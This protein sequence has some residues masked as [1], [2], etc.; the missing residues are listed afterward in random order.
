M[1]LA[2]AVGASLPGPAMAQAYGQLLDSEIPFVTATGR[3]LG[4][5][6]RPKPELEQIG[7]PLGGFR[8]FPSLQAGV[9]FT[10]NVIGADVG[11][12]TDG[13]GEVRPQVVVQSQWQRNSLTA[14]AYYDGLRYFSTPQ[15]NQ[16][17]FA[18]RVDGRI[19]IAEQ[20]TIQGSAGFLR[21][22]EDQQAASF[23]A[24]G[25]GSIAVNQALAL[26]R[27][28]YVIN[29]LRFTASAD[30]NGLTY[31]STVTTTGTRLDLSYRDRD[32]YRGTVR[33]EYL[34]GKD[35]SVFG[36]FSFRRTDYRTGQPENDRTSNE[37]RASVGAIA[38]VTNLVRIAGAIGYFRRTYANDA[39]FSSVGGLA[40]D[41]RA[42]YYV[43]TLTT[44]SAIVSRQIEEAAITGSSGYLST[45][46]GARVDHELLR[47][48]T[49]YVYA[50]WFDDRFRGIDRKDRA[51]D[52]GGGVDYRLN[53]A[54]TLNASST[55]LSRASRGTRRGPNI[56]ELRGL[57]TLRFTP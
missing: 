16:N 3:N 38:D 4:V 53:R 2:A 27:G 41:V 28:T 49:P 29:R 17:G 47:N 54:F 34:L 25:G 39:V 31:G 7:L 24:G 11:A 37:W 9:G 42:D 8:V 45:R 46:V 33:A 56:D 30:Y 35:N 18:A 10:T 6:D 13:Y 15:K 48:L 5:R 57:L 12:R 36:Q 51:W 44:V 21:S 23:P 40:V 26:V 19:D 32:V 20:D 43:S 55:Y 22:Y 14:T 50:D 1:T 52:A